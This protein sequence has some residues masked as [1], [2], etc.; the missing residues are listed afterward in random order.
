VLGALFGGRRSARSIAGAVGGAASR[1]GVSARARE[2]KET[3]EH[4]A[5]RAADD[6]EALE[7]EILDDVARIDEEWRAKAAEVEPVSIRLEAADVQVAEL[8]LVW[9]PADSGAK[10]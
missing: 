9:V 1:R 10:T 4:R 2:R 7:Q 3:A 6:L 5:E 8:R